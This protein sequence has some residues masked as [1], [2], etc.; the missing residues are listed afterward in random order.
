MTKHTLSVCKYCYCVDG[1]ISESQ[2]SY[3]TRLFERLNILSS[4]N[5]SSL[6]L[7][8]QSVGCMW[9]CKHGCVIAISSPQKLTYLITDLPPDETAAPLLDL[10][11]QYISHDTG[12]FPYKKLRELFPS[13][14]LV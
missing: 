8:I 2:P 12:E 1:K 10:M 9:A 13:A 3:G 6:Q 4:Q 11:Q 7:E 14:T 5:F